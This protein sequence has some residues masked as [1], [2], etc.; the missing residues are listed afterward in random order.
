MP[1]GTL[2]ATEYDPTN[3]DVTSR[4][5]AVPEDV[6]HGDLL[7]AYCAL[8]QDDVTATNITV[9]AGTWIATTFPAVAEI[10]LSAVLT[11]T[12]NTG[13]P[14]I[15]TFGKAGSAVPGTFAAVLVKI[16]NPGLVSVT[17]IAT[18]Q[19]AWSTSV[20]CPGVTVPPAEADSAVI[21]FYHTYY[22][23]L[24]KV[25]VDT[26]TRPGATELADQSDEWCSIGASYV[27]SP[28]GAIGEAN[29]IAGGAQGG[30]RGRGVTLVVAPA[31][32]S[33]PDPEPPVSATVIRS[34]GWQFILGPPAPG[35]GYQ[36]GVTGAKSRRATFRLRAPSE[37]SFSV[38]GRDPIAA[39]VDELATDLFVVRAR[40]N[41]VGSD[42][43]FRGRIGPSGDTL[44]GTG[45]KTSFSAHD[46]REVLRRRQLYSSSQLV[47][48]G[49][50]QSV[51]ALGLIN[52]TQARPGGALGIGFGVG[53]TTGVLRDRTEYEAGDPIG[54]RLQELSEVLD[55]FD[56]DITPAT[57]TML[58]LDIWYP[59]RGLDR[60]VVLEYGGLVAG[61]TRNVDP[62]K[63]ANS[64]RL[65]GQGPEAGGDPPAPVEREAA[66]LGTRPEGR[67]DATYGTSIVTDTT[68]AER[69][70]WQL[71]ESEVVRPS[72][73]LDLRRGAWGG[74]GHIWLGDP[75][76]TVI[77]SGRLKID[78]VLR[79]EEIDVVIPDEG[80]ED[81]K[82]TVGGPRPDTRKRATEVERRL[83]TLERR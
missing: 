61:V 73:T 77:Y 46:Y 74:P 5:L 57:P 79:V 70:D 29:A 67:W 44:D 22:Y 59:Q 83:R 47:W 81:V 12:W 50:D 68:L 51:I 54:D 76:R 17:A 34:R 23:S 55:G 36:W 35:G 31:V 21:N 7:V 53:S 52:Q 63:Y 62:S 33:G 80:I 6:E 69:G 56:W 11:K 65:T 26:W 72:Y 4:A 40:P 66:D 8:S 27:T 1:L 82:I 9:S 49:V 48:E 3:P 58:N 32:G 41:G 10:G 15:Y 45:H 24:A 39:K 30:V 16:G 28:A 18:N 43:L 60:G 71:A 25:G 75:V 19:P 37:A 2:T 20:K 78:T 38:D 42:L 13:D 64:V 14:M